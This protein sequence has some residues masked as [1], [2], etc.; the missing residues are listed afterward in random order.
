MTNLRVAIT[1]AKL[2]LTESTEMS[3]FLNVATIAMLKLKK[4][5]E[6]VGS[7]LVSKGIL[8]NYKVVLDIT[9][10][11]IGLTLLIHPTVATMSSKDTSSKKV[12]AL[13]NTLFSATPSIYVAN[14]FQDDI[15]DQSGLAEIKFVNIDTGN[16]KF[17]GRIENI[18]NTTDIKKGVSTY[19]KDNSN[20]TS[21]LFNKI[22]DLLK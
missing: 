9:N 15:I 2:A 14:T 21:T 16:T 3:I 20:R 17:G 13:V 10:G 19:Y 18:K 6:T 12:L 5:L 7:Y 1:K 11:E 22:K 8:E 4:Q